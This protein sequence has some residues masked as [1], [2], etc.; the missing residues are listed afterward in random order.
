MLTKRGAPETRVWR[1]C[2]AFGEPELCE[3]E[4]RC[5]EEGERAQ[6]TQR[7]F[8]KWKERVTVGGPVDTPGSGLIVSEGTD[9]PGVGQG[10][11]GPGTANCQTAQR[12]GRTGLVPEESWWPLS[13]RVG[14]VASGPGDPVWPGLLLNRLTRGTLLNRTENHGVV[15][16]ETVRLVSL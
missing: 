8:E 13:P 2:C 6:Q 14:R 11:K 16:F 15:P 7:D 4:P 10:G 3:R 1:R 12:E 9:A 5:P